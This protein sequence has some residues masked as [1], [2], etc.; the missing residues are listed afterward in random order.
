MTTLPEGWRLVKLRDV[1]DTALGKMLDAARPKGAIRVPYLRNVNVQWGHVDAS[2][3]LE[4]DMSEEECSRFEL[5]PGDLLVCEGGEI[6]RAAVWRGNGPYMAYQKALHRVRSK[7]ELDLEY[8]RYLLEYYAQSGEL[9]RRA[10][11]STILHLPQQRLRELPVPLPSLG[12]QRQIVNVLDACLSGLDAAL[13]ACSQVKRRA[14]T[15]QNSAA[16]R[17]ISSTARTVTLGEVALPVRGVTYGKNEV[18]DSPRPGYIPLL[19]ASNFD[20]GVLRE[21]SPLVHV[22][23]SRVADAQ[24]L[25]SGDILLASS[26]GSPAV[27]GKSVLI[28][29]VS[30]STFGAFCTVLRP[31]NGDVL[32]EYL[33]FWLR[34]HEV[35]KR[36]SAAAAGTNINNLRRSHLTGTP[37][38]FPTRAEQARLVA[39]IGEVN[40]YVK[41]LMIQLQQQRMRARALRRAILTAAFRDGW[42]SYSFEPGGQEL[43][44]V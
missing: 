15:L 34:R 35:R 31:F 14:V 5:R 7:G 44:H 26:S 13:S 3:V 12:R 11:G 24:F 19:R 20:D 10:T 18:S 28:S 43:N 37:V 1:A 2:N 32:P 36:W 39:D 41:G 29:N 9:R 17:L 22:H 42:S 8:L 4:V 33:S 38:L 25:R 30:E 21:D 27:V 40:S 23:A 6:G 16:S